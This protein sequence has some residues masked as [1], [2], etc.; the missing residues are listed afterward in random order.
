M[1]QRLQALCPAHRLH[2]S[3]ISPQIQT[4]P[5]HTATSD[6]MSATLAEAATQLSFAA[7]LERCIS[8]SASPPPP[9]PIPHAEYSTHRCLSGRFYATLVQG[10]LGSTFYARCSL[11]RVFPIRPFVTS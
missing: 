7:F 5:T 1:V 10:V 8:V 2:T 11:P 9:L 6:L 4:G 3:A